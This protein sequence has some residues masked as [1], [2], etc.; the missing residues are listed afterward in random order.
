MLKDIKIF[1]STLREG[2]QA[3]GFFYSPIEKYLILK[4]LIKLPI[5]TIEL[6]NYGVNVTNDF[7][8]EEMLNN[9]EKLK[10]K[11]NLAATVIFNLSTIKKLIS[12]SR[13]D[14][15]FIVVP[16]S[17]RIKEHVKLKDN[18][19]KELT[20]L[21]EA[22]KQPIS[23]IFFAFMDFSSE[24]NLESAKE[25]LSF[26]Y[27]NFWIADTFG[28]LM[29]NQIKQISKTIDS[30]LQGYGDVEIGVH[31]H[32]DYG[33]ALANSLAF[34]RLGFNTISSSING[35]GERSGI[36]STEQ[37]V[38]LKTRDIC[39]IPSLKKVSRMV[40]EFSGSKIASNHPI[41]GDNIHYI[42]TGV[43]QDLH[44][45]GFNIDEVSVYNKSIQYSPFMGKSAW[46]ELKK[47]HHINGDEFVLNILKNS[48]K[49]LINNEFMWGENI[50][51]YLVD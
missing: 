40:Q 46:N 4:E 32:N 10:C 37:L 18:T 36:T 8:I 25:Y 48:T 27:K 43:H 42:N 13:P 41:V 14:F 11:P 6:G 2:E 9:K 44:L 29:P 22:Y 45:K 19:I 34:H 1:D 50:L 51:K 17:H 38:M 28:F 20:D 7:F 47:T 23:S 39:F 5:D 35:I 16:F 24:K 12:R 31:M 33:L 3:P 26:G 15:I 30:Y 49:N 21:L